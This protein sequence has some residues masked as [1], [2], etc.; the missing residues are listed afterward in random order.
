MPNATRLG[1]ILSANVF[2][3][4][5]WKP[6]ISEQPHIITLLSIRALSAPLSS[7]GRNE[8]RIRRKGQAVPEACLIRCCEQP[9]RGF[10]LL[11]HSTRQTAIWALLP[12]TPCPMFRQLF[13]PSLSPLS[14]TSA[15][16]TQ[17]TTRALHTHSKRHPRS[18]SHKC[19]RRLHIPIQTS[20]VLLQLGPS[21]PSSRHPSY[22]PSN[23]PFHSSRRVEG[24]PVVIGLFSALKSSAVLEIIRTTGRVALTFIPVLLVKNHT[25]RRLLKKIEIVKKES[26]DSTL[27]RPVKEFISNQGRL[28]E[29]IRRRTILFHVLVFTPCILF[30]AAVIASL[31][32]TPLTGR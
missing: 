31:E 4:S 32:R 21:F 20:P 26:G 28:I 12:L 15:S 6:N 2:T 25:S 10:P 18:S 14:R 8:K 30:W 7:Q 22:V 3:A 17:R 1:L 13:R 16:R 24:L 9:Q 27:P 19:C 11:N 5:M 29:S 23:R